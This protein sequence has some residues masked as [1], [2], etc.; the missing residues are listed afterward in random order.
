MSPRSVRSNTLS[1]GSP[2]GRTGADIVEANREGAGG[3]GSTGGAM[4]LA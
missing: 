4:A 1:P 2:G 3:P